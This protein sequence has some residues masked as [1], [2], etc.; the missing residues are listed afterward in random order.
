MSRLLRPRRGP[1]AIEQALL[2][3]LAMAAGEGNGDGVI[4][5]RA[6]TLAQV[7]AREAARVRR[8]GGLSA[9]EQLAL[10]RPDDVIQIRT[11]SHGLR[12][13]TCDELREFSDAATAAYE[14][15]QLSWQSFAA[16]VGLQVQ[17]AVLGHMAIAST[18]HSTDTP[19]QA[20]WGRRSGKSSLSAAEVMR[21]VYG[22]SPPE[23]PPDPQLVAEACDPTTPHARLAWLIDQHIDL[24][25]LAY[26]NPNLDT[27]FL[28]TAFLDG[29]LPTWLN[30]ALSLVLL[31]IDPDD[32]AALAT[33][34]C[35]TLAY[36]WRASAGLYPERVSCEG[37]FRQARWLAVV[38]L[39]GRS[40]GALP[41]RQSAETL[42][43]DRQVLQVIGRVMGWQS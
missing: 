25:L 28:R 38:Q 32:L 2:R 35:E 31:E 42:E 11:P 5:L 14:A 33:N 10:V 6:P 43:R 8:R 41:P 13:P 29:W 19:L 9:E 39:L 22:D 30:P 23:P 12:W 27:A 40:F 18:P 34:A 26:R 21:Q 7:Q 37:D 4:S 15:D 24:A 16:A 20:I 36:R 3:G 17:R 1:S